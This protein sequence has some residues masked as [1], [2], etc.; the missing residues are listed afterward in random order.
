MIRTYADV[1]T[2]EEHAALL[3]IA[4]RTSFVD[5]RESAGA[6]LASVKHNEQMA[7]VDPAIMDVARIVGAALQR[8]A[9]FCGATLPRAMHSLRLARYGVGMRYGRHVDAPIMHEGQIPVRADLSFTLFLD[10]PSTYEGGELCFDTGAGEMR[11]KLPARAV[12]C[13]PTGELHEVR[14]VTRGERRVVVGWVESVVRDAAQRE[15]LADLSAAIDLVHAASGTSRAFELL[16]KT[17][18]NL[19]RRWSGT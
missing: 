2:A 8:H 15:T 17:H 10:D 13:Y 16:T 7:R 9:G 4:S 14:E 3:E 12:V 11:I 18:A 5:G 1:I 19:M 6:R